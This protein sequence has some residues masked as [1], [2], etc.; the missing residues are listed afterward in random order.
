MPSHSKINRGGMALA[1]SAGA[2]AYSASSFITASPARGV[3][4][5]AVTASA[6]AA[7]VAAPS[8]SFGNSSAAVAGVAGAGLAA[9]MGAATVAE[10][11]KSRRSKARAVAVQ[12]RGGEEDTRACIPLEQVRN[13]D[14]EKVGGKSASLG[15]M[16]SQLAESGVPVPGGFST[17]SYAYKQFLDK[18]GIN[19]YINDTLSDDI[20]YEDVNKLMEA[21]KKCRDKIMDTNFQPEFE[22]EL[23]AEW[24]RVSGGDEKF[25][26]AVRSSATAEDLPDA[27]FAGQQETYLNVMG[28]EEMKAK[29][30]L[31]FASLFTDR[32]ISY[33]HDKGFDHRKVQLCATCQKMVRSETGAAGVMFSLDTESGFKDIV[34]V[35]SAYGLGETV[36]GGTVNPDEWYVFKPTLAQGKKAVVSR[37]MGSKL[38]KMVY[39]GRRNW[40]C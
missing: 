8:A 1:A 24:L 32:A 10:G 13:D 11:K 19:D 34:F 38:E 33:R 35:T 29:V 25:T 12:A 9:A 21:G 15:E 16:I 22:E 37:T 7:P 4:P 5:H 26:F 28:Y 2:L 27:S 20:I 40:N 31:V 6:A 30:H 36:V 39:R 17:T 18:G 23:K 14:V 3:A